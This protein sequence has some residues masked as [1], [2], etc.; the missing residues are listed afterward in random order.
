MTIAKAE[1]WNRPLGWLACG[2]VAWSFWPHPYLLYVVVVATIPLVI[3]AVMILSA[4]RIQAFCGRVKDRSD[5]TNA[6]FFSTLA[7]GVRAL[8][9]YRLIDV[10]P[11]V[12]TGAVIALIFAGSY[13]L[14]KRLSPHWLASDW[15]PPKWEKE[16]HPTTFKATAIVGMLAFMLA[17]GTAVAT[18]VD[19]VGDWSTITTYRVPVADKGSCANKE[20]ACTLYLAPWPLNTDASPWIVTKTEYDAVERGQVVCIEAHEG[21]LGWSWVRLHLCS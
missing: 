9:D 11:A 7:P 14:A 19:T 10:K 12:A 13:W 16:R 18:F 3:L 5:A 8:L 15:L 4:G 21:R 2:A 1:A 17:Y 20:T 6:I